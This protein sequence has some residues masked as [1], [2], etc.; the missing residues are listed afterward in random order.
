MTSDELQTIIDDLDTA[1]LF[2]P[3]EPSDATD[4]DSLRES[5]KKASWILTQLSDE[6][7]AALTEAT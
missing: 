5:V 2:L 3:D 1:Q 7:I 6:T 4:I